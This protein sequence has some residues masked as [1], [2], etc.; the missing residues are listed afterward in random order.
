MSI[1]IGW[2]VIE[3][4]TNGISRRFGSREEAEH[5][6]ERW[7]GLKLGPDRQINYRIA[8]LDLVP[9]QMKGLPEV[10]PGKMYVYP[11]DPLAKYWLPECGTVVRYSIPGLDAPL[12]SNRTPAAFRA[13]VR[14]GRAVLESSLRPT[15]TE[16]DGLANGAWARLDELRRNMQIAAG[17]LGRLHDRVTKLEE[18]DVQNAVLLRDLAVKLEEAAEGRR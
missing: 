14:E 12:N 13:D 18:A 5:E 16:L 10:E 7:L 6:L 8:R 15:A 11:D 1:T 4:G 2:C 17:D 3:M 9:D